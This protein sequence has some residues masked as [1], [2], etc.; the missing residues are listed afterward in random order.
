LTVAVG[1]RLLVLLVVLTAACAAEADEPV[2]EVDD[3]RVG[4]PAGSTAAA[5]V[6][7]TARGRTD[8]L[9]GASTDVAASV[10][11]H[12]SEIGADGTASMAPVDAIDLPAGSRVALEPGG[13]H[14]MLLE[15]DRLEPG[16]T[17]EITLNFEVAEPMTV[18]F[19]VVEPGETMG[20]DHG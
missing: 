17:V 11:L 14:I 19:A 13:L 8:Q 4:A 2:I 5:Y 15:V 10:E 16:D 3:A 1:R 12:R 9:V 20:H 7:L 6:T 18:S